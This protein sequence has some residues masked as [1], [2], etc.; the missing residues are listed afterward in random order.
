M[1]AGFIDPQALIDHRYRWSAG[2]HLL[3]SQQRAGSAAQQTQ[4]SHAYNARGQLVASVQASLCDA[5]LDQAQE[6]SVWRYAYDASQRRVLSQQGV[7][8]QSEINAATERSRFQDGNHRLSLGHEVGSQTTA[9]NAN[10]QP[11]RLGEREFVWDALGRLIEVREESRPLARYQYDHRGLRIGK[12]VMHSPAESASV[13][14]EPVEA[15]TT[16]STT[17]HTLYDESRQPLA[18]LDAQGRITRQYVWLADLPLAVIDTPQGTALA[19]E[20]PGL[21]QL[22]ADARTAINSWL[23]SA[24]GTAWFHTNHLGAPEAATNAQGQLV[25]R[26][27]YAPFGAATV[28][29]PLSPLGRGLG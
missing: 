19:A 15:L 4:L 25:W 7:A 29:P 16:H 17:T 13:R 27:R 14:A 12:T 8:S 3:H 28:L 11:E 21:A 23:D 2:G 18:E 24:E 9:Y 20:A 22:W 1:G 5:A 10:D 6:Q 26:A